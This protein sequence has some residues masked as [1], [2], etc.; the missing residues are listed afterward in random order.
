MS[1]TALVT[2]GARGIGQGIAL[3]LARAGFDIAILSLE[4]PAEA[5]SVIDGV[6]SLGR[7]SFY[8]QHDI[9]QIEA[10]PR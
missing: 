10:F 3:A 2:G 6:K 9:S 1:R 4:T 8:V 7:R 5:E